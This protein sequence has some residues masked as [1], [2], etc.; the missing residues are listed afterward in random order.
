MSGKRALQSIGKEY[1]SNILLL[2]PDGAPLTT[3]S[4][5]RANWYLARNLA[6][7]LGPAEGYADKVQLTFV[8][9]SKSSNR[10]LRAILPTQCVV[11]GAIEDLTIHHVVPLAVKKFFPPELKNHT[12]QWCVLVCEKH[13]LEAEKLSRPLYEHSLQQAVN[14]SQKSLNAQ[15]KLYNKLIHM[16]EGESHLINLIESHATEE[17]KARLSSLFNFLREKIAQTD[18]LK[19]FIKE[20]RGTMKRHSKDAA[21]EWAEK[22]IKEC[23]GIENVKAKF[24]DEFLKI[25]P[26]F[27]NEGFLTDEDS[28]E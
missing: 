24:R 5:K 17:D 16:M 18:E 19:T 3:I 23:G 1:Y 4:R 14:S 28:T 10:F 22:F 8:P 20:K 15:T 2:D 12:R 9:K 13:H 26:K 11:C 27:L 25:N 21:T 7:S 6:I